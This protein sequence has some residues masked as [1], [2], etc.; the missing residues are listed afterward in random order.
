MTTKDAIKGVF[1]TGDYVLKTY[2]NDLSDADL[3]VRPVP[4]ANHIAWQLGHLIKSEV[5]ML[6]GVTSA[7]SVQLPAGFAEKHSK[8]TSG[9]EPP[10]GMLTKAE[11]LALYDRI[12]AASLAK[13][14]KLSD[15]DLDKPNTG[16]L[17]QFFPTVGSLFLIAADHPMMHVGQFVVVRRKLGKPIVM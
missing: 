6:A 13:L 5:E 1:S 2:L 11:Y 16:S 12:R 9:V 15:A 3:L 14:D 10:R 8:E 17:A 7:P 4:Q